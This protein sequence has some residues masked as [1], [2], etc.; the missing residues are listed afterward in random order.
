MA[1]VGQAAVLRGRRPQRM[2]FSLRIRARSLR[3]AGASR[4][5]PNPG[6]RPRV[7]SPSRQRPEMPRLLRPCASWRATAEGRSVLQGDKDD[8]AAD[9]PSNRPARAG[10]ALRPAHRLRPDP[11]ALRRTA[12]PRV[13]PPGRPGRLPHDRAA[14][15]QVGS[16][17]SP[18]VLPCGAHHCGDFSQRGHS[19]APGRTLRSLLP[20]RCPASESSWSA[21]A[22][23]SD[24]PPGGARSSTT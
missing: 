8:V 7:R 10:H 24:R 18:G 15:P 9:G 6:L 19:G 3:C 1:P 22:P 16:V 17:S 13:D 14:T 23:V 20:S 21:T 11:S 2:P 12:R 5:T 4:P